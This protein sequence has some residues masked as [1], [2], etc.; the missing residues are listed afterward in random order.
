MGESENIGGTWHVTPGSMPKSIGEPG[1]LKAGPWNFFEVWLK[2]NSCDS[3]GGCASDGQ[4]S[5]YHTTA[6]APSTAAEHAAKLKLYRGDI[7]WR[8]LASTSINSFIFQTFMGGSQASWAPA[9]DTTFTFRNFSTWR[10]VA[11]ADGNN[12]SA[13]F[14][15]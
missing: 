12:E 13:R 6:Y 5:V 2:L 4:V 3:N 15:G 11:A 1:L 7:H 8:C 14:L 10:V 9:V